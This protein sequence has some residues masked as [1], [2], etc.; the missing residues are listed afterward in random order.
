MRTLR[1]DMNNQL[2]QIMS[3]IQQIP[4]LSN[5]KLVSLLEKISNI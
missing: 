3:M 5:I 4:N 2:S 1:E